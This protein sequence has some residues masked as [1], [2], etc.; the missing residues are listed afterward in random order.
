M[1]FAAKFAAKTRG[2]D[3]VVM[4][5]QGLRWAEDPSVFASS[6]RSGWR[7]TMMILQPDFVDTAL[8]AEAVD[9]VRAKKDVPALDRVRL[10]TYAEGLAAQTMHIGP[11]AEEGPTIGAMPFPI[12]REAVT[13]HHTPQNRLL[14]DHCTRN[15]AGRSGKMGGSGEW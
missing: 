1:A 12:V 8:L 14:R 2:E 9:Q 7:W 11:Y 3:F 4:P 6:D 10:E 13:S 15:R 5:L